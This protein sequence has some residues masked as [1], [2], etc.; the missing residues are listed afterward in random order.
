MAR[1]GAFLLTPINPP[2]NFYVG[3]FLRPFPENEAHKLFLG[4]KYGCFG[5]QKMY[6]EKVHV[7]FLSP[8]DFEDIQKY[9]KIQQK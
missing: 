8:K 4:A 5:G 6:V 2:G 1:L 9:T 7:L 3:P